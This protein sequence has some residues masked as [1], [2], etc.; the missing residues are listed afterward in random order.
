MLVGIILLIVEIDQN[1]EM[2]KSQ[3]RNELAMGVIDLLQEVADNGELTNI[4]TRARAGEPLTP[5]EER[6]FQAQ[7]LALFR[8][9]ENVH[10]QYRMGLYDEEEYSKHKEGWRISING[11]AATVRVW[12]ERRLTFSAEYMMEVDRL[13]DE[14]KCE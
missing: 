10:Y 1:R 5:T 11:G 14:H 12:C 4:L 2:L 9:W 13:L 8:Y 7:R 3:T 6:Q